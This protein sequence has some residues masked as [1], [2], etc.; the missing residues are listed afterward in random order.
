MKPQ[1]AARKDPD[2][3]MSTLTRKRMARG[4]LDVRPPDLPQI[5][6]SAREASRA[7]ESAATREG[8]R[9]DAERPIEQL[10]AE[11]AYFIY[12]ARD[13][14]EG[15]ALGDWLEAERQIAEEGTGRPS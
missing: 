6:R 3:P 7:G 9:G 12:L 13:G 15:D 14:R 4:E 1:T 10:V 8:S 2:P 11:R 5:E